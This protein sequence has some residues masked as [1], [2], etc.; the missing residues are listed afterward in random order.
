MKEKTRIVKAIEE[1]EQKINE[2]SKKAASV[3][4]VLDRVKDIENAQKLKEYT[5]LKAELDR[6]TK[7]LTLPS[8][9]VADDMFL[10]KFEFA[11][12]KLDRI[13]ERAT[14]LESELDNLKRAAMSKEGMSP[15]SIRAKIEEEKAKIKTLKDDEAEK[16]SAAAALEK[17]IEEANGE[18]AS[19]QNARKAANLPFIVVGII[20][21]VIGAAL[22]FTVWNSIFAICLAAL[23]VIA[24]IL[25][26]V[27]RP[28]DAAA[29][30][31]AQKKLDSKKAELSALKAELTVIRGEINNADAKIENLGVSLNFGVND[32]QKMKDTEKLLAEETERLREE[33]IRALDFFDL[34]HDTDIKAL[35]QKTQGLS[36]KA[37]NQKQIKLR[38]SYLS[39]D[40]GNITYE[41]ASEK[42]ALIG[43]EGN[44][45]TEAAVKTAEKIRE[46][47]SELQSEKARLETEL[48]TGFRGLSDP[49]DLRRGIAELKEK[50]AAK[51]GYYEAAG[52]AHEVLEES[53][54]TARKSFGGTLESETLK[55]FKALTGG[56]YG[57]VG[58]ST[59]FEISVEKSGVF[60]TH[61]LEYLSRG[62]KD[63]AYLALR[64][65]LAKLITEKEPLPV[66]LDDALSQYDDKRFLAAMSFLKDY[67]AGGQAMLFT[68]HN[69]VCEAAKEQS[70][71]VISL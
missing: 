4:E 7:E 45:D 32:E 12:S 38:L 37:E 30:E 33:S 56:A 23:G 44:T 54:M 65:A 71:T 69:F 42:L 6:V 52:I 8:G 53:F 60:G 39:R 64:L 29:K 66:I 58:V 31:A 46:A 3:K 62:A 36:E 11:F 25:G 18:L 16:E 20:T 41:Q 68:C 9:V 26:F 17:E 67:S 70:V 40:L 10:K 61:E 49:E 21:A 48:K 15:D 59:D 27:I 19:A 57:A 55:N 35:R 51:T 34:P 22:Y 63:Q 47:I 5:E 14:S 28:R 2:M 50:I 43:E 24:V 1:T 13:E